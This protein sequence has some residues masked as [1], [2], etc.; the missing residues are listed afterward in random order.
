MEKEYIIKSGNMSLNNKY[1][2]PIF[3]FYGNTS[4]DILC[5]IYDFA[6]TSVFSKQFISRHTIFSIRQIKLK[7]LKELF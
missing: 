7:L 6:S 2:K 1:V 4:V 5:H 3:D